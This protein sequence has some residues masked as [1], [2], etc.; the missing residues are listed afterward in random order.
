[1]NDLEVSRARPGRNDP[2]WCGSGQKYKKCHLDSDEART[3]GGAVVRPGRRQL[4]PGKV[5]PRRAVP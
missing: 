1:M 4:V 3:P 2:C 5:T